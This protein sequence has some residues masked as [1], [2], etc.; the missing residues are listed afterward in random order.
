MRREE[1]RRPVRPPHLA[2]PVALGRLITA[3]F[4]DT[5]AQRTRS[6]GQVVVD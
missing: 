4:P 5:G 6:A 3:A 1:P 2:D